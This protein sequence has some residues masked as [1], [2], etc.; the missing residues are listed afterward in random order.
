MEK[1][2]NRLLN[3]KLKEDYDTIVNFVF[4]E[5][6]KS[7]GKT[8]KNQLVAKLNGAYRLGVYDGKTK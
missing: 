5:L 7:K 6:P 4:N 8:F 3:E 1:Y 2:K